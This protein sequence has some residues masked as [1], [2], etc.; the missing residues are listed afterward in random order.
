M[1]GYQSVDLNLIH[2]LEWCKLVY[3]LSFV[4]RVVGSDRSEISPHLH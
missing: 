2:E 4:L 1:L 3:R